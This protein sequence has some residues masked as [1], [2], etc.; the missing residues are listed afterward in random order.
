LGYFDPQPASAQFAPLFGM[1]SFLMHADSETQRFSRAASEES[2]EA[3]MAIDNLR[4]ELYWPDQQKVTRASRI[5]FD[6][7]LMKW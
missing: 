3:E 2:W 4:G 6:D 5:N 1:S 7:K